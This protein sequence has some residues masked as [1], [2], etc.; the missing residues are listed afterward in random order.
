MEKKS[1]VQIK[2]DSQEFTPKETPIMENI[3]GLFK[4]VSVA[5]IGKPVKFAE[6]IVIYTNSTTYRLYWF[7]AKAGVWHYITATA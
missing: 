3:F 4:T 2:Y 1:P 7:D 6:Q 5:P